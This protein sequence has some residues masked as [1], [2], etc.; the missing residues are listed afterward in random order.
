V[1]D[2]PAAA[3]AGNGRTWRAVL[4]PWYAP[5]ALVGV[6]AVG[7]VPILVPLAVIQHGTASEVGL[8]MAA[9]NLGAHRALFAAGAAITGGAVAAFALAPSLGGRLA[10]AFIAGC[11]SAAASTV[12]YLLV[13]EAHPAD[14]WPRRIGAVQL[15]YCAGQVVGLALA[16][17]MSRVDVRAGLLVD[18]ALRQRDP[19]H[20]LLA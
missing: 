13:V 5:Y 20:L 10:L 11:G 14:E 9:F 12:A 6:T 16:G 15:L 4:E 1:T 19:I 3:L 7:G 18:G 2:G 8:V 17:V